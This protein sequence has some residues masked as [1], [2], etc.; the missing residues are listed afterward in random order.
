MV[1][2]DS[3]E[4]HVNAFLQPNHPYRKEQSD[5]SRGDLTVGCHSD[6]GVDETWGGELRAWNAFGID[7]ALY[8]A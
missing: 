3:H 1:L 8:W 4:C 7:I 6:W 2:P 5:S